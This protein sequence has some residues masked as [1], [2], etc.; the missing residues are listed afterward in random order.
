MIRSRA[1]SSSAFVRQVSSH[2]DEQR[3]QNAGSVLE[4][5]LLVLSIV[6]ASIRNVLTFLN[7]SKNVELCKTVSVRRTPG[8]PRRVSFDGCGSVAPMRR[9][10]ERELK[11]R[12]GEGFELPDLGGEALEARLFVSPYLD[13]PD[14]RLARAG[15][16][17]GTAPRTV[18]GCGS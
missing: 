1:A 12:A 13:A 5:D 11:L 2:T 17:L 16:T 15:V 9:T 18:A 8:D 10:F 6:V 3:S 7:V 14:L 4:F